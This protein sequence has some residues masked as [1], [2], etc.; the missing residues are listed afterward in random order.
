MAGPAE[1]DPESIPPFGLVAE[2]AVKVDPELVVRDDEQA[3]SHP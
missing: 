1:L 3:R 2:Q